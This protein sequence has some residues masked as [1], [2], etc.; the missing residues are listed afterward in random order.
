MRSTWRGLRNAR[1]QG[2]RNRRR[3]RASHATSREL[4][5][6]HARYST[7]LSLWPAW[8]EYAEAEAGLA[9]L[10]PIAHFPVDPRVRL[11]SVLSTVRNAAKRL[12]DLRREHDAADERRRGLT[13][14]EEAASVS[15]EIETS[16]RASRFTATAW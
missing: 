12:E 10:E 13:L 16:T 8:S 5:K 14:D 11:E 15:E 9:T 1:R 6:D 3:R 4:Q 2:K 7:L